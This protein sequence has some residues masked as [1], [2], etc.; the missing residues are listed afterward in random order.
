MNDA[1]TYHQGK[2]E[3]SI[4]TSEHPEPRDWSHHERAFQLS[5]GRSME[6]RPGIERLA[7]IKADIGSI[8]D[9]SLEVA[10]RLLPRSG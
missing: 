4:E 3:D 7:G 8:P 2:E 6:N 1:E 10:V 9:P 5:Y